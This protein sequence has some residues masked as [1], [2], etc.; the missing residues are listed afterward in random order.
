MDGEVTL[1]IAGGPAALGGMMMCV[2]LA[3]WSLGRWQGGLVTDE[4]RRSAAASEADR[5]VTDNPGIYPSSAPAAPCQNAAR[6]ERD[7][8]LA[9][10]TSLGDMHAE[11]S[12]YRRD[13]QVLAALKSDPLHLIAGQAECR[14][15]GIVG[16]PTCGVPAAARL[17]CACAPR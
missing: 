12:A 1:D 6:A 15:I 14:Y 13:E 17:A 16:T 9:S 11:I 8:E 3:A 7:V 5:L 2:A 4:N 10:A